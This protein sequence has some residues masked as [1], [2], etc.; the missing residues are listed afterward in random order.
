MKSYE[1]AHPKSYP[2]QTHECQSRKQCR[3][4]ISGRWVTPQRGS[5]ICS[6]PYFNSFFKKQKLHHWPCLG[7]DRKKAQQK[8]QLLLEKPL[9]V[10]GFVVCTPKIHCCQL[11]KLQKLRST[12]LQISLASVN[13]VPDREAK[14]TILLHPGAHSHA[15]VALVQLQDHDGYTINTAEVNFLRLLCASSIDENLGQC[16][17][18]SVAKKSATSSTKIN[19]NRL[20]TKMNESH[21]LN[22]VQAALF[23]PF[24]FTAVRWSPGDSGSNDTSGVAKKLSR[25]N[26]PFVSKWTWCERAWSCLYE[27]TLDTSLLIARNSMSGRK[28]ISPG[29]LRVTLIC[30]LHVSLPAKTYQVQTSVSEIG[31][32][33]NWS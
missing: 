28:S 18:R 19:L 12:S 29:L 24:S 26:F 27:A 30:W 25:L 11:G 3:A 4:G 33:T 17:H 5:S 14:H 22:Q 9:A 8:L 20:W 7:L 23:C 6:K 21:T 13:L 31:T 16:A 15:T 1:I 10:E 32:N 2:L